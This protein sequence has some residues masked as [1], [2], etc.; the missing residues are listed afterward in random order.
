MGAH[1]AEAS[2]SVLYAERNGS[3][4]HLQSWMTEMVP[5]WCQACAAACYSTVRRQGAAYSGN[6]AE[7][8]V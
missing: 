3:I 6:A 8:E 4:E 5:Q 2:T 1:E 7:T